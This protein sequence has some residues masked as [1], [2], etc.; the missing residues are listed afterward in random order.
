MVP[1]CRFWRLFDPQVR[2][3]ITWTSWWDSPRKKRLGFREIWRKLDKLL[4]LYA[5][6][7]NAPFSRTRWVSP[8]A[9]AN[10]NLG[11]KNGSR[12]SL[13]SKTHRW[14][15]RLIVLP[16]HNQKKK[17]TCNPWHAMKFGIFQLV[18]PQVMLFSP[19]LGMA[20]QPFLKKKHLL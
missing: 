17:R 10:M 11:F 16:S 12:N 2:K 9:T 20:Y 6:W 5:T 19:S 3:N 8:R 13:N 7:S 18:T 1:E 4:W 15:P 14:T